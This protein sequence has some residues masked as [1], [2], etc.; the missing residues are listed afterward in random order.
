MCFSI[1]ALYDFAPEDPY[2]ISDSFCLSGTVVV[3]EFN[4]QKVKVVL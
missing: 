4:L 2:S 3:N 1:F